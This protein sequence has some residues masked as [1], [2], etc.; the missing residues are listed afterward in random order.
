LGGGKTSSASASQRWKKPKPG[1]NSKAAST[2]DDL[3]A[4]DN[5][6]KL[7][8]LTGYADSLLG[9]G[10]LEI[11]QDTTEKLQFQLKML[12][13]KRESAKTRIPEGELNEYIVA[14]E[15]SQS[16]RVNIVLCVY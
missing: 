9:A 5:K 16:K 7:L 6:E 4:A 10:N 14:I 3:A 12:K 11:Y 1:S 13:E 2:S 15:V 8:E